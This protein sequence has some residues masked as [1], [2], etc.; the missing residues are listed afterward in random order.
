MLKTSRWIDTHA[1]LSSD[2]FEKD[3]QEVLQRALETCEY[4]VEI[5]AGTAEDAPIRA[6]AL[7]EENDR[8]FFTAG[9]HPHDAKEVSSE[10]N[11]RQVITPHFSH[12]KCV[13]V[14]ECGLD[15][16]YDN[17]PR[18]KQR[19]VFSWQIGFAK[20]FSLPLS[21]HSREAEEDTKKALTDFDGQAVFHCFTGSWDMARFGVEKGFFIS[22]SGIVTFKAAKDLQETVKK[23]PLENLLVETDAPFLAPIPMRGKRNESSFIEHTADFIAKLRGI[24]PQELSMKLKQNSLRLFSKISEWSDRKMGP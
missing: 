21:I 14:G 23:L 15:Y 5:G 1:H 19:E 11:L 3:R 6:K 7:A 8:I 13:A 24:D 9:V 4:L 16:H 18:D 12:P 22:F 2:D 20:E 10:D 17:S